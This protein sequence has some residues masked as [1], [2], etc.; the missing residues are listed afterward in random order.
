[1]SAIP[2]KTFPSIWA[3]FEMFPRSMRAAGQMGNQRGLRLM[4]STQAAICK[5]ED[6]KKMIHTKR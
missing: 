4:E 2:D 3:G 6:L 5:M 1:M